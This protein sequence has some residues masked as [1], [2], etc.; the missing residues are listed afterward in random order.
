V[1]VHTDAAVAHVLATHDVDAVVVGADAVLS[2]G[3]VVNKTGT[4]A[5][6]IAAANEGGPCTPRPRPTR[7]GPTLPSGSRTATGMPCTTAALR[8][9]RRST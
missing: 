7:C 1:T 6:A 8:S 5:A 2:D 9:T 3:R 4:R